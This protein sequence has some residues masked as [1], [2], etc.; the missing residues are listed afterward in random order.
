MTHWIVQNSNAKATTFPRGLSALCFVLF[1]G[2]LGLIVERQVS[3]PRPSAIST[4][5]AALIQERNAKIPNTRHIWWTQELFFGKGENKDNM[6]NFAMDFLSVE[7]NWSELCKLDSNGDGVSNG[8]HLGDPCCQWRPGSP[9]FSLQ[10]ENEYRRWHLSHPSEMPSTAMKNLALN[11]ILDKPAHCGSDYDAVQY[12]QQFWDFY[13]YK[14]KGEFEETPY[15]ILKLACLIAIVATVI[16]WVF[17]KELAADMFPFVAPANACPWHVSMLVAFVSFF[18]MDLTSG[19]IHLIL[20][21][22][23]A[24]LP[25]LGALAKGFQYHHHDPTAIIRISWYEYASHM[26]VLFPL[27]IA[28]IFLSDA[29]RLQRLFWS[30]GAVWAH[31]FQTAHRWAH[32]PPETL[33]WV[34]RSLQSSGALLSHELHMS[35]HQDLESQFT[36]LSG[37]T[38]LVLDNLSSLVPA[39][40]YDLWCLFGVFW[41]VFPFALDVYYHD[42]IL[43]LCE[44]GS[45]LK[46]SKVEPSDVE[47]PADDAGKV[48][49]AGSDKLQSC[50]A[51]NGVS[52]ISSA[53]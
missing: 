30:W 5:Q 36:I 48:P 13:F 47:R 25:G 52:I 8:Q 24:S 41:F 15:N 18:Y 44:P 42:A 6:L 45:S 39:A 14:A 17:W 37:H 2:A 35:H 32:M 51:R 53:C 11:Q 12:K 20:D 50:V 49:T 9:V 31:M 43:E 29:T 19:I 22:A 7:G 16:H 34:V 21:Y 23:P 33:P 40:R 28:F 27:I 1:L 3:L 10:S 38:D 46:G 4:K 26:H